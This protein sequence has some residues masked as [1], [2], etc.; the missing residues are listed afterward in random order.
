MEHGAGCM[1]HKDKINQTS[2]SRNQAPHRPRP[3]LA[4]SSTYVSKPEEEIAKTFRDPYDVLPS[5]GTSTFREFPKH[6]NET[7]LVA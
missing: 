3:L 5:G 1:E 4:A 7:S 2:F 6:R